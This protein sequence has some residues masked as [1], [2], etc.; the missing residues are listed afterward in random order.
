MIVQ[1]NRRSHKRTT[2]GNEF[3]MNINIPYNSFLCPL[4]WER[5]GYTFYYLQQTVEKISARKLWTHALK[6][7]ISLS[8]SAVEIGF[9]K[10][11]SIIIQSRSVVTKKLLSEIKKRHTFPSIT[12]TVLISSSKSSIPIPQHNITPATFN[13]L[14]LILESKVTTYKNIKRP[15]IHFNNFFTWKDIIVVPLT[16]DA[17]RIFVRRIEKSEKEEHMFNVIINKNMY[18]STTECFFLSI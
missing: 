1:Y 7:R 17:E 13:N 4:F 12:D 9:S 11:D 10:P 6:Y 14:K 2:D 3:E 16:I 15:I 18:V 5:H 8:C